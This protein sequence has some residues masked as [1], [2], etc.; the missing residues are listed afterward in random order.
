MRV[1]CGRLLVERLCVSKTAKA[2]KSSRPA[3]LALDER[4]SSVFVTIV[5][6]LLV[7]LFTQSILVC[8]L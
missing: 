5:G 4:A 1:K 7:G 6:A 8:L 2:S 3:A